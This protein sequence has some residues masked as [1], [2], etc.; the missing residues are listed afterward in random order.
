VS[1]GFAKTPRLPVASF[2]PAREHRQA[3]NRWNKHILGEQY[4]E[5]AARLYPK[6]KECVFC[7]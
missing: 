5:E 7:S 6:S 2:A 4:I 1:L 3:I